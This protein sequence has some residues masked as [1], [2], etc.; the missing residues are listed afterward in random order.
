MSIDV[1]KNLPSG[2]IILKR[3]EKRN[4]LSR[5]M[6][7]QL[8]EALSDFHQEKQVRAVII[9]GAGD[10]FCSGSDLAEIAETAKQD[11][12]YSQWHEDV[13]MLRELLDYMLRFPK[14][15]IAAIDGPA[16]GSGGGLALAADV[17]VAS[18]R[19]SFGFPEARR[20]LVAGVVAPLLTFRLGASAA[21]RLLLT[22]T[23]VNAEEAK[24]LGAFDELVESHLVWA[25]A[26][27]L[28]VEIAKCAPESLQLTKRLLNET[29]GE[30]ML[31][32]FLASGAAATA[33]AR[34]TEASVEG[35]NA[36]LEKRDPE[37]K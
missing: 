30:Q 34:T 17:V 8:K 13:V 31:E 3:P 19:S 21:A 29:I 2:T 7:R 23:M 1:K 14:P 25:R 5:A 10:A 24:S 16:V 27:E 9:T 32:S 12:P 4:A 15:I 11:N 6:M 33:T 20:G 36:F 22:G 37:W 35:V 18:H 26:H 28:A